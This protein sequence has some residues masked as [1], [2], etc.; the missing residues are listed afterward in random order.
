M[1]TGVNNT[2]GTLDLGGASTQI[3]FY[4]PS[5]D[6][7]EGLYNLQIGGQKH[8]N[9]YTKSFLQFGIV[10]ARLRHMTELA[11]Q[12]A[13]SQGRGP[14]PAALV[15]AAESNV[16]HIASRHKDA[17]PTGQPTGS[18]ALVGSASAVNYC[19]HSGYSETAADTSGSVNVD[20]TGPPSALSNQLSLCMD[21]VRGLM[22]KKYG[23]FCNEVYHGDCSIAGAYQ[24][25]VPDEQH[26]HFIGQSSYKYPWKFMQLPQTASLEV[27]KA[28]AEQVCA[29]SFADVLNYYQLNDLA[30]D[31]NKLDAYLPYYCFLSSYVLVL[32]QG[33]RSAVVYF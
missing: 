8:W 4:V 33:A 17:L 3:A 32:L 14:R 6:I 11:D 23:K 29:M 10:S 15:A 30:A 26:G 20:L 22:E 16:T 9:V 1:V 5:Q 18:S 19:F 25:P 31:P 13:A 21:S 12:Y 2:Y 27:F 24:P 7:N 28:K